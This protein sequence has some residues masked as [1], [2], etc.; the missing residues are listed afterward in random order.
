MIRMSIAEARDL[1]RNVDL[2]DEPSLD[3]GCV[4]RITAIKHRPDCPPWYKAC[5]D[6]ETHAKVIE[7][8]QGHYLCPKNGKIYSSYLPRYTLTFAVQ[9][10][11]GHMWLTAFSETAQQILNGVEAKTLI[12]YIKNGN[13]QAYQQ[14]FQQ[15][16]FKQYLFHIRAKVHNYNNESRMGYVCVSVQNVS[17]QDESVKLIKQIQMLSQRKNT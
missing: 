11:D 3:F 8:G 4:A 5:P 10:S 1:L 6:P 14:V 7:D 15:A 17:F 2:K 12:K 13:E 16:Y 9:G